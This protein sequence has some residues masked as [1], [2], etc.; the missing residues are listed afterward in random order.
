MTF[1]LA[2][3]RT[4]ARVRVAAWAMCTELSR[5]AERVSHK[6]AYVT[7]SVCGPNIR[8][9]GVPCAAER[10]LGPIFHDKPFRTTQTK[11]HGHVRH[12]VPR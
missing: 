3:L 5:L 6:S 2:I 9:K 8:D 11:G 10:L 4:M 7:P 12:L 1:I